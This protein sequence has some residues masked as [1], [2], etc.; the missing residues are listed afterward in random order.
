[1]YILKVNIIDLLISLYVPVFKKKNNKGDK[2][3]TK[4]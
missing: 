1:M 2:I 3:K 4:Y